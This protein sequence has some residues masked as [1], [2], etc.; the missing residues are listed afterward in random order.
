MVSITFRKSALAIGAALLG[1]MAATQTQAAV[2]GSSGDDFYNLPATLPGGVHG[3]LVS[4]RVAN[5][6]LNGATP[7][8]NAWNVTY[9]SQDSTG[10]AVISTGTVLVPRAAAAGGARQVI[11]YAPGVHGMG[12]GCAPSRQ[13]AIDQ[14]YEAANIAAA[15]KAGY[16]VLVTDYAGYTNGSTPRFMAGPSQGRNLLD[17]F[18]AANGIPDVGFSA[19]APV[20]IWGYSQGG[21]AAA[22]AA[23]EQPTYTPGIDLKA[24][25]HGGTPGDLMETAPYLN[26]RNGAGFLFSA[27]LGLKQEYPSSI[28]LDLVLTPQGKAA[29]EE[30]KTKCIFSALYAYQNDDISEYTNPGTKLDD[31]LGLPGVVTVLDKQKLGTKS[32]NVP[33]YQYHGQADEFIPLA[34]AYALK[35]AYCAKGT[36]VTFDLYP[37]EHIITQFQAAPKVLAWLG[38]RFNGQ[39]GQATC[40][41]GKPDPTS[42]ANDN[43]GNIKV[44]LV[45]WPLDAKVDLKTLKQT[46]FLPKES[47]FSEETDINAK[48]LTGVLSV[49]EFSQSLKLLGIGAQIRMKIE[50][51]GQATGAVALS[52]LGRLTVKGNVPVNITIAS[53]W[54]IPFGQCKTEKPVDFPLDF[55][56]PISSLGNGNLT[57]KGTTSFPMIKGCIISAIISAFMTGSGQAY[58]FTVSPPAPLPN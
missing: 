12:N 54:G 52:E 56:G 15:L 41:L 31:L 9:L 25:A 23:E 2:I 29:F 37:G 7:D 32:V 45:K 3:D 14:E 20:A 46:V 28:P 33:M 6:R 57:F 24:V 11:L 30:V 43:T 4:Y 40:N 26:A 50:P 8:A 53:V 36:S 55:E 22:F 48:T 17:I 44:S 21:Q 16:A 34:Q 38:D 19:T 51:A 27:I 42:T 47:T 13:F 10:K 1:L 49:P 39:A 35:K 58:T 5:V 18:K